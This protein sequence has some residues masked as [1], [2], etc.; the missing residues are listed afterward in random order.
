MR[1]TLAASR[2]LL[3]ARFSSFDKQRH[4]LAHPVVDGADHI[5]ENCRLIAT[6]EMDEAFGGVWAEKRELQDERGR[7]RQIAHLGQRDLKSAP[8]RIAGNA[9]PIDPAADDEEVEEVVVFRFEIQFDFFGLGSWGGHVTLCKMKLFS[10][11]GDPALKIDKK[12][13]FDQR[14]RRV[15]SQDCVKAKLNPVGCR[16]SL[17]ILG[18]MGDPTRKSTKRPRL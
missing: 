18:P 13:F 8:R 3:W 4:V 7:L 16:D 17:V 2:A 6:V 1:S 11:D 14:F 12:G 15:P 10:V 9:T 5:L